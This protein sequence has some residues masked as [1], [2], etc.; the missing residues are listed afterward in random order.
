MMRHGFFREVPVSMYLACGVFLTESAMLLAPAP[1]YAQRISTQ[2]IFTFD[3]PAQRLADSLRA[4]ATTAGVTVA[5]DPRVVGE[6][7]APPIVG[8][9]SVQEALEQLLKNSGLNVRMTN[10]GSF[11]ISQD[12]STSD[13]NAKP[14][15]NGEHSVQAPR[16]WSLLG[17][18]VA[19]LSGGAHS[20]LAAEP[21]APLASASLEEIVV[22]AQKR[23]ERLQDVPV[24]VTA[25]DAA[26]LVESNQVRLQDYYSRVPGLNLTT[27]DP[28]SIGIPIVA[29]RGITSAPATNPTVGIVVDD[30]PF[31][32]STSLGQGYQAPDIN[33]LDLERVEVLRG[34]QGTLYGADSIGG[35]LKFVTVDPSTEG[36]SGRVQAGTS[37][38][39]N[40]AE[41]GYDMSV[42]VNVPVGD[43]LALRA[44]GFTRQDPGYIDDPTLHEQGVNRAYLNGGRLAALWRPSNAFSLK[45]SALLQDGKRQGTANADPSLGDLKQSFLRGTGE[46][47]SRIEAYS[48]NMTA[49]LGAVNV[50]SLTGYNRFNQDG[51]ID[52]SSTYGSFFTFPNYG[53]T[54]TPD[55]ISPRAS[56]FSQELR[57]SF[58]AGQKLDW[59]MGLYY[60]HQSAHNLA[61][62][63]A[64]D[65][66][67]LAS[68]GHAWTAETW[69]TFAEYAAFADLTFHVSDRFDVQL[70]ARESHIRQTE[71]ESYVGLYNVQVLGL[72]EVFATPQAELNAN[73]FTYLVTP[74]LTL[75]PDLMIYARLASGYRPGGL[76]LA[77]GLD[78]PATFA[79]D[80][81]NNYE[82][83]VKGELLDRTLSFDASVYY[84]N[85]KHIQQLLLNRD[86]Q[87]YY[88]NAGGARSEGVELSLE[89]RPGAG[90]TLAGWVAWNDAELTQAF[91]AAIPGSG[92]LSTAVGASGDRLPYSS[93]I[94]G[95]ISANE[96]FGLWG[97]A[98]G[99]AAIA[100]SYVGDREGSFPNAFDPLLRR[101]RYPGYA[102]TD[103]R[104]GIRLDDW[105]ATV[106]LTN[107]ADRRGL[108]GG[109][110]GTLFPNAFQYIQPRT[111]GLSVS[112][113][114]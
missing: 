77:V 112:R 10:G 56:T 48:A 108:I 39:R 3:I 85:W 90:L 63:E 18:M 25:I 44:S 62:I 51:S 99:F 104:T 11:L 6:K 57:F 88:D 46:L 32:S 84:I 75:S 71:S 15:Q 52:Y 37:S 47:S 102:Q 101:Q 9:L 27:A 79:P 94:S 28:N 12:A 98:R 49:K 83:G 58:A 76:N 60:T 53:V 42:A 38:V 69:S 73:S 36:V 89:S 74:R 110:I 103:L 59:L 95:R 23:D 64:V 105:M 43:Q 54:G 29:I 114:F 45:L 97:A 8:S 68:A 21:P 61:N 22:T 16:K 113:K 7:S 4:V 72:P 80:K 109:G 82:I 30:V 35:L 93:R 107:V 81:T 41:P 55:I 34:P 78:T 96:D 33:P 26:D 1:A 65:A 14:G 13:L 86:F 91:P 20:A 17:A 50:T 70:G 87:G 31:G 111:L 67:T 2:T 24:P 106:F 66:T 92:N 5:F 40:G 19:F 100:V